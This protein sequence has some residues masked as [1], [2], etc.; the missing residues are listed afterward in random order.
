MLN[1][2]KIRLINYDLL[3]TMDVYE[4]DVLWKGVII[5]SK[6]DVKDIQTVVNV[7]NY[8]KERG[9]EP[10]ML[11]K[12]D[13]MKYVRHLPANTYSSAQE[14]TLAP[15]GK[16]MEA[17][18]I[19]PVINVNNKALLHPQYEDIEYIVE[20]ME[21]TEDANLIVPDTKILT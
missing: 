7:S 20:D 5:H 2:K 13:L 17:K 6:G 8:V 21:E 15:D 19:P 16:K 18:F 12:I 14:R 9:L 10:G 1:V 11:V 3:T 4:K